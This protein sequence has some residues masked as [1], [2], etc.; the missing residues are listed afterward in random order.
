MT[1]AN[2]RGYGS[3]ALV[4][5]NG[6]AHVMWTDTRKIDENSEEIFASRLPERALLKRPAAAA[7]HAA[8]RARSRA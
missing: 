2:L 4:A 8:G 1:G 3:T 5:A 6:I 7:P